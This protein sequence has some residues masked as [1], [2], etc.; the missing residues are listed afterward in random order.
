MLFR[1]GYKVEI[2]PISTNTYAAALGTWTGQA[3][4]TNMTTTPLAVGGSVTSVT[5]TNI[6]TST[7][8]LT[9]GTSYYVRITP[10]RV[11]GA[12]TYTA[13]ATIVNATPAAVA[14]APTT[15]A[16][17][18]ADGQLTY[19]WTAPTNNGGY[20]ILSYQIDYQP[21]G[22]STWWTLTTDNST[23]TVVL[24]GLVNGTQY[25]V[26]VAAVTAMGKGAWATFA[27]TAPGRAPSSP[28]SLVATPGDGQVVISWSASTDNGGYPITSYTVTQGA[29]S[30]TIT[31]PASLT[32]TKTGLTNGTTVCF[33]VSATNARGTSA[34]NYACTTPFAPASSPQNVLATRGNRQVSLTWTAPASNGGFTV[35]GYRL[36]R[37]VNGTTW[38]FDSDTTLT[39]ATVGNLTNGV[40]YYFRVTAYTNGGPAASP[41]GL[42][43]VSAAASAT[44]MTAATAPTGITATSGNSLVTLSWTAPSDPGGSPITAYQIKQCAY[45]AA[46][47]CN[48]TSY[49]ATVVAS[50]NS[51]ATTYTI[52]GLTN[53]TTY[54]FIV[55]AITTFGLGTASA[56]AVAPA[57]PGAP[58]SAPNTFDEIGRA[59]V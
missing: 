24:R 25:N 29:S 52:N 55:S 1:S 37:S 27:A 49:Y 36:E 56:L 13:T 54:Y 41:G 23:T 6:T 4:V 51:T 45:A 5:I 47:P 32:Y 31:L 38:T 18:I 3:S 7:T 15:G 21:V 12:T 50:T 46:Q 19:A 35:S 44:P 39:S 22:A 14:A 8:A 40:L 11:V 28:I 48:S 10:T 26:R 53:G 59:H 16:I 34:I 2:A 57:T 42:G 58:A 33:N 43:V 17:T 9:T 20:P 30:A